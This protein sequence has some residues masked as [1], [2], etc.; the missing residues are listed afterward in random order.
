MEA[1]GG[2]SNSDYHIPLPGPQ[3]LTKMQK[4][5]QY[6]FKGPPRSQHCLK[7]WSLKSLRLMAISSLKPP[8]KSKKQLTYYEHTINTEYTLLS[9]KGRK[10]GI[11]R[12]YWCQNALSPTPSSFVDCNALFLL[13]A[14]PGLQF[15]SAGIPW[16]W[17]LQH[18]VVF[19]TI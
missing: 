12:E 18:F 5:I 11:G 15:S 16:V 2:H 9:W 3:R 17:H 10:A 19:N 4:H 7:V 13:W 14:G 8:V 1:Y 6:N